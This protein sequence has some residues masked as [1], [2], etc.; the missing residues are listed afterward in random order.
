MVSEFS[1]TRTDEFTKANG[2]KISAVVEGMKSF[3]M[4]IH[5]MAPMKTIKQ[6]GKECINGRMGKCM[7]ANG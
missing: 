7:M 2:F 6:M 4:V 1:S 5:T 3:K